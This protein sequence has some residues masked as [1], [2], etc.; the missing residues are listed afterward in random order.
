M[1][2]NDTEIS[3]QTSQQAAAIERTAQELEQMSVSVHNN[4]ARAQ[5]ASR[6][7]DYAYQLTQQG[8]EMLNQTMISMHEVTE[9]S[10][11]IN[12]IISVVNEIASQTNL[13][14]LNAAVEAARAG[15]AGKGFAVV[16]GEVRNLAGRSAQAAREIRE[17]IT[18]SVGK[19]TNSN[20]LVLQSDNILKSII[21]SIQQASGTIACISS[22]GQSQAEGIDSIHTSM[23]NLDKAIQ[24]N[25]K[26][27]NDNTVLL[28]ELAEAARNLEQSVARFTL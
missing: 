6:K 13:L 12:E 20:D 26:M 14:A 24:H 5:E 23:Q 27:V 10:K 25:T 18:D 19:I 1:H 22:A 3:E 4:A 15:E 8:G 17:L 11:K 2:R 21:D 16:A 7:A 9:S 28:D